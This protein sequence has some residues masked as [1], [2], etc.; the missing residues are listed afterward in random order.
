MQRSR[1]TRFER[2]RDVSILDQFNQ[3]GLVDV[4]QPTRLCTPVNKNNEGIKNDAGHLMCYKVIPVK[5][6]NRFD[7][8]GLFLSNQFG[9][10][11]VDSGKEAEFCVPSVKILP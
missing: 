9:S 1:G 10:E 4:V 5:R 6:P 11:Q 3:P 7:V 2:I 8:F